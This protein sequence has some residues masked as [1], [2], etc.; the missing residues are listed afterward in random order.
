MRTKLGWMLA[1]MAYTAGVLLIVR[2]YAGWYPNRVNLHAAATFATQ[3]PL[4][5]FPTSPA[6]LSLVSPEVKELFALYQR[7]TYHLPRTTR[8]FLLERLQS[9]NELSPD[10]QAEVATLLR[11]L[12]QLDHDQALVYLQQQRSYVIGSTAESPGAVTSGE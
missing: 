2:Q 5:A 12:P 8:D 11:Q 6:Y 4:P 9:W 7:G 3:P 10:L 1:V